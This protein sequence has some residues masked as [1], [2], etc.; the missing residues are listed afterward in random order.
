MDTTTGH[1]LTAA[2]Y[3]RVSRLDPDR[4]NQTDRERSVNQQLA[5]NEKACDRYGWQITAR[6]ADPGRSASRFATRA[7]EN[8][9]KVVAA[10]KARE[11]DVLVIWE[12]SRASRDPE[13]WI[14]VLAAAAPVS[15]STSPLMMSCTT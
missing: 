4:D 15:G 5:A 3:G 7:R 2:L 8:W 14:P 10:I 11:F 1:Q 6:Y 13:E 9:E 12:T